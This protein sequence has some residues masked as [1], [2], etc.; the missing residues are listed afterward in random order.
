VISEET[1]NAQGKLK[2]GAT[3]CNFQQ[4][5]LK[6]KKAINKKTARELKTRGRSDGKMAQSPAKMTWEFG[7]GEMIAEKRRS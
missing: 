3:R 2:N 6:V 7:G 5:K 4:T 1:Y